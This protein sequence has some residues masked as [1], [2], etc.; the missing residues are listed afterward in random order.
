MMTSGWDIST[1]NDA[2]FTTID[3]ILAKAKEHGIYCMLTPMSQC[4]WSLSHIRANSTAKWRDYGRYLGNRYKS[5]VNIIW[6]FGNDDIDEDSQHAIVGGIKNAGDT[7]LMT[8][9]W[10]PGVGTFGSSWV[11]KYQMGE[12]W[13]DLDA[14]YQNQ[15]VNTT[16]AACYWQKQEYERP[17]PMPSFQTEPLYQQPYDKAT[18]LECRMQNYYVALGGGCGGCIYGS[19][20]LC[21][22]TDYSTYKNNGGRVQTIY[23]KN[24]F[25]QR[26]WW[27]LVPD[28]SHRFV[29]SGYGTLSP[30]TRDYV[31]AASNGG[32]LG[33]AYCPKSTTISADL[34][35]FSGYVVARW[36]DPTNGTFK[37]AIGSPFPNTSSRQFLTPGTNGAGDDD[38]VLLL[39][40]PVAAK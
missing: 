13:I 2:Y 4:Q 22:A 15:P 36:Y 21:D 14:W 17:N 3:A 11:R 20:W 25:T 6:Q 16:G 29:T 35:K 38:W 7:H 23:F 28:Y 18:D 30:S 19:G 26:E 31:G 27:T 33:I 39:E 40:S 37:A 12:S 8:C 24:L 5:T 1:L 9:N 32:S 10:R 34:S